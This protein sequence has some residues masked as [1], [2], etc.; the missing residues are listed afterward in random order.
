VGITIFQPENLL[1]LPEE[2]GEI[3]A[4]AGAGEAFAY[5]MDA[6]QTLD[7]STAENAAVF[8]SGPGNMAL[9]EQFAVAN[10]RTTLEM[11]P[12]GSWL[13]AQNLFGP[14]SPLTTGEA[15]QVWSVLSERFAS[16]ASGNA[17]GFVQGASPTGIFNSVEYPA[18]LR[19]L[20][21]TNVITGGY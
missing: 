14:G 15:V 19:N 21:I 6:A 3:E 10:G 18:L 13:N 16:G 4:T 20:G 12:G 2:I 5:Y 17:V 1:A 8:Y 7:V 11:T 9:A